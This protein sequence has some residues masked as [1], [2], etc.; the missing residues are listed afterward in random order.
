MPSGPDDA[1]SPA[2]FGVTAD[3]VDLALYDFGGTG[4]D[5]LL[6]HATG[7]CAGVLLPLATALGDR[8]HCLALDLRGHGRSGRPSDGDFAWSGFATDVLTAVD[9]FGL[10]GAVAVGHSCGGAAL[11]LAEQRRPGTFGALYLFEPVVVPDRPVPSPLDENPLSRGALRRRETFPDAQ[12]AFV[13]FASKPPLDVLD[14]AVLLRYVEDGFEPVPESDGGDG[15]SIRLRC[16]R[17]DEADVYRHGFANGAFAHLGEVGCPVTF[18]YGTLTDAFGG[19]IMAADAAQVPVS[20]VEV[21]ADLGHFGPL[22][23]PEEVAERVRA[24]LG[25]PDST[26][27]P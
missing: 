20:A 12:D 15:A 8:F 10:S 21:F 23:Q 6:V 5:L 19:E 16:R 27:R 14:P 3:G 25:H 11:L 2:R 18:A 24:V 9:A 7:F 1:S 22:E 13:N 4:P 17:D 26:P